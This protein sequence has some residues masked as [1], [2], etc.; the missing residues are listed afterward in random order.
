M[1]SNRVLFLLIVVAGSV[2]VV[3]LFYYGVRLVLRLLERPDPAQVPRYGQ[4]TAVH[5]ESALDRINAPDPKPTLSRT[6]L[7][8]AP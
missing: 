5:I 4:T 8:P 3:T 1:S 7:P 6:S 2:P